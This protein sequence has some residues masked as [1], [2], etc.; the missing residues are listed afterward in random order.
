[1]TILGKIRANSIQMIALG[2]AGIIL[3]GALLLSLPAA[4]RDGASIPFLN[5]LFTS[6]S[7]TCVT[8]L[9]VYDTYMQFTVSGQLVI[10]CLIQIGGLGFM[11]V[12]T[13]FFMMTRRKIRLAER[14]LLRRCPP[15]A[16]W[17][18]PRALRA[19]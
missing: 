5:A 16:R 10:L 18:Y 13:L 7:A 19:N 14:G 12:A 9:V 6:T 4:S 15:S 1:M 17:V 3:L 8:G 11:T 2:F